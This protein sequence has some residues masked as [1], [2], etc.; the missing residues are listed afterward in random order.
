MVVVL[1]RS[2][3]VT[4]WLLLGLSVAVGCGESTS[5]DDS[6]VGGTSAAGTPAIGGRDGGRAGGAGSTAGRAGAYTTGGGSVGVGGENGSAGDGEQSA[7]VGG[8]GN[9][10][11]GAPDGNAGER[12][13]SAGDPSAGGEAGA[14]NATCG[15][16]RLERTEGCD[17]G[18]LQ[19]G[20][21]CSSSCAT[22]NGSSCQSALC[23]ANG[24]DCKLV[25][26]ATFRDFNAHGA[27][28]GHPD[29]GPQT[30]SPGAVVLGAVASV[31]DADGKPVL[32]SN[33][34]EANGYFHGTSSFAEWYRDGAPASSPIAGHVTLW[35]DGE[36]RYVN[37][38][39]AHGEKWPVSPLVLDYGTVTVGGPGGTGCDVQP[40]SAAQACYDP[41]TPWGDGQT[42]ACCA[43]VPPESERY[44]DGDP[45]FFPI[46]TAPGI[47]V[48]ARLEGEVPD[49]FGWLGYPKEHAVAAEWNITS[50]IVT[51]SS[52][53][54]STSHNFH[55]TTELS[56]WFRYDASALIR[57][58]VS[59]DDDLWLF[60][61]GHLAADLGGL[62]TP[63]DGTVTLSGGQV[64]L[65]ETINTNTPPSTHSGTATTE[66]YGLTDGGIYEVKLFH[67]E[68]EPSSSALRFGVS[69][70]DLR[71][72]VCH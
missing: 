3:A 69:G 14:P 17:D 70:V 60:I 67:A 34:T 33:A 39:G 48:E 20:D 9:Q 31:L 56:F 35:D 10:S 41:C 38:W 66:S 6:G 32:T 7:G 16:G 25:L 13:A 45:L 55:F 54:P 26:P 65:S 28:F 30:A 24:E 11:G 62:H 63:L 57:F 61:N 44:L 36:G 40:C 50:P 5:D 71:R 49:A 22:E 59:G 47:L 37:R 12:A 4:V 27:T 15:N 46:D 72:S 53:F 8:T 64:E 42:Q 19:N 43:D 2:G 51:A 21:G 52:T 18:N 29:F 58:D 68:R 1:R 23:D